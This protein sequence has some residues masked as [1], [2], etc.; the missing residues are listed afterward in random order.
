MMSSSDTSLVVE[1]EGTDVDGAKREGGAIEFDYRDL[2]YAL[3]CLMVAAFMTHMTE[4]W[5]EG[6]KEQKN[7]MKSA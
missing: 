1:E 7:G 4:K 3:L 5:S 2:N 6:E